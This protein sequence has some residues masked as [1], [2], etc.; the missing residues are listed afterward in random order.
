MVI[1][2]IITKTWKSTLLKHIL[3]IWSYDRSVYL[4]IDVGYP[5]AGIPHQNS[6]QIQQVAELLAHHSDQI[7]F[8]GL[9]AHCGNSYQGTD[10]EAVKQARDESIK[11]LDQVAQSLKDQ[12]LEV[13]HQGIGSTPSCSQNVEGMEFKS[14]TEI[15]PGNYV[16]YDLQQEKVRFGGANS[17]SEILIL[18][19]PPKA[20]W[21]ASLFD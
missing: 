4:K 16:F 7:E 3:Y 5:R 8:Q 12:G 14:L 6:G 21:V 10:D 17:K 13:K 18:S 9:Y 15:H 19:L 20:F 11:K 1:E 2:Q